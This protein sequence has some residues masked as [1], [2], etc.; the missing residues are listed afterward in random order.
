M[1]GRSPRDR[2][3]LSNRLA[4]ERVGKEFIFLTQSHRGTERGLIDYYLDKGAL[5][6][7]LNN[8]KYGRAASPRPPNVIER[9]SWEDSPT[10]FAEL[11]PYRKRFLYKLYSFCHTDFVSPTAPRDL[12]LYE[13]RSPRGGVGDR[14]MLSN[15]CLGKTALPFFC[16]ATALQGRFIFLEHRGTERCLKGFTGAVGHSI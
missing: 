11:L 16:A 4:G 6:E 9:L 14:R 15:G 1:V 3:T 2:R 12:D 5:I 10:I 13:H 8:W 7:C